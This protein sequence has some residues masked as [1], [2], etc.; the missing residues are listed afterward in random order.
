MNH[1]DLMQAA[2]VATEAAEKAYDKAAAKSSPAR[3][4][5]SG[6]D[7]LTTSRAAAQSG[8]VGKKKISEFGAKF[9][10]LVGDVAG[11]LGGT[12]A[13]GFSVAQ[14]DDGSALVISYKGSSAA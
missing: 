13:G 12:M 11:R 3:P 6:A 9:G 8:L 4:D 2:K 14:S 5:K 7:C 1:A 10:A